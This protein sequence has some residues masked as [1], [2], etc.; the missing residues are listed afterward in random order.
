MRITAQ[1]LTAEAFA[2]YGD[3]LMPP[4]E[5]GRIYFDE[6]LSNARPGAKTSLSLSRLAPIKMPMTAKLL[7]RHEFSSQT[8]VP[9]DVA[10]WVIIVAPSAP[11]GG[12]D[13]SRLQAF[14]GSAGLGI[15]YRAG[16]WHHGLTVL[17]RE[18]RFAVFMWRDG[19][20]GDEEFVELAE[21]CEV[22]LP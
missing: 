12:P 2:P 14:V 5:P 18:A 15:T 22:V 7:E 3:V 20:K 17:D 16:T 6:A 11:G 10:R 21:P 13:G 19:T 1:P 9:L 4:P 8:F